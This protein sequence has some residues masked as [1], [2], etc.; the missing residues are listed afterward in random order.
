MNVT[1]LCHRIAANDPTLTEVNAVHYDRDKMDALLQELQTALSSRSNQQSDLKIREMILADSHVT[2]DSLMRLLSFLCRRGRTQNEAS[3]PSVSPLRTLQLY[4][5]VDDRL[6]AIRGLPSPEQNSTAICQ[7][8]FHG[9]A[10][11]EPPG[12]ADLENIT[13]EGGYW[14]E[15]SAGAL[16]QALSSTNCRLIVLRVNCFRNMNDV[17]HLLVSGLVSNQHGSCLEELDLSDN[18]IDDTGAQQLARVISLSNQSALRVLKLQYNQIGNAGAVALATALQQQQEQQHPVPHLTTL[19]L[20]SNEIGDKGVMALVKAITTHPTLTHWSIDRNPIPEKEFYSLVESIP[21]YASIKSL[22]LGPFYPPPPPPRQPWRFLTRDLEYRR[23]ALQPPRGEHVDT[24][25]LLLRQV[26]SKMEQNHVLE[27]L[28][29]APGVRGHNLS[30]AYISWD[31]YHQDVSAA[32]E[33]R[34]TFLP[35]S[36]RWIWVLREEFRSVDS[37]MI[38]EAVFIMNF[39]TKMNRLGLRQAL[40]HQNLSIAL[41]PV[42]LG[43]AGLIPSLLFYMLREHPVLL[44]SSLP[45]SRSSR[46]RSRTPRM[47]K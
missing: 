18:G 15:S 38:Q 8:L 4:L 16:G 40:F 34:H 42:I 46:K 45:P 26:A 20:G 28:K 32:Q 6:N 21:H 27:E 24:L 29:L 19:G 10:I 25:V 5:S 2:A 47:F 7:R 35:S 37:V 39:F 17:M 12:L 14:N 33:Q 30:Y 44:S 1:E 22:T 9:M 43:R 36:S 41:W 23:H 3:N 11:D 31:Q 13:L